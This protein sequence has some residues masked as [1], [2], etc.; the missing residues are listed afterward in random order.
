MNEP[1]DRQ[2]DLRLYISV[3]YKGPWER[4]GAWLLA[5]DR[6]NQIRREIKPGTIRDRLADWAE[7]RNTAWAS[8]W[9]AR[10]PRRPHQRWERKPC[11]TPSP[12]TDD[13]T[14]A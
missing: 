1:S 14:P 10:Y 4:I 2:R 8:R 6:N 5:I 13:P 3:F 12:T 9:A 7:R 11:Q